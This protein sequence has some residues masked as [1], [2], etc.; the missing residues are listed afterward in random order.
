MSKTIGHVNE[1]GVFSLLATFDPQNSDDIEQMFRLLND[2]NMNAQVKEYGPDFVE[3]SY[4]PEDLG[5][6]GL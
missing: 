1:E 4:R 5:S 2:E 6:F 3:V